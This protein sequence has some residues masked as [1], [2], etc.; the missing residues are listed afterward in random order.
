MLQH[1]SPLESLRGR[2]RSDRHF[3]IDDL[4]RLSATHDI[5]ASKRLPVFTDSRE[6]QVN[7]PKLGEDVVANRV[8]TF[9]I[10]RILA[11]SYGAFIHD[12]DSANSDALQW[13]AVFSTDLTANH[14]ART[15]S[16][17]VQ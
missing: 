3:E 15:P 14:L 10:G 7:S 6:A 13:R 8:A 17:L 9:A 12:V 16:R 2:G 1:N 4:Q 11:E 5:G